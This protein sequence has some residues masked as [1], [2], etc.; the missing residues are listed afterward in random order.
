MLGFK[1][2]NK[3]NTDNTLSGVASDP[4]SPGFADDPLPGPSGSTK[5]K[6]VKFRLTQSVDRD[7]TRQY[8]A[9]EDEDSVSD[10]LSYMKSAKKSAIE[11]I[12]ANRNTKVC[13]VLSCVMEKTVNCANRRL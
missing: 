8:S 13:M 6:S 4:R 5:R 12:D 3:N 10:A 11:T 9:T 1:K 7:V 2:R